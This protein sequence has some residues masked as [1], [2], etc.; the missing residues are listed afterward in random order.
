MED[1]YFVSFQNGG[2]GGGERTMEI[3]KETFNELDDRNLELKEAIQR[4][5][6]QKLFRSWLNWSSRYS[7]AVPPHTLFKIDDRYFI[8]LYKQEKLPVDFATEINEEKY[9][10]HLKK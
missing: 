5:H 4:H 1:R 8:Q 10:E 3:T 7:S 2:H 6:N 9:E